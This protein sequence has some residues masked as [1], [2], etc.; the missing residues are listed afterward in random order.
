[1]NILAE[2]FPVSLFFVSWNEDKK[3]TGTTDTCYEHYQ[4]ETF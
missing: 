1:M 3:N 2:I 4:F